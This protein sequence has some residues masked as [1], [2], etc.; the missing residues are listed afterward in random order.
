MQINTQLNM[1]HFHRVC[2]LNTQ[3]LLQK[4]HRDKPLHHPID[5]LEKRLTGLWDVLG[6]RGVDRDKML[7]KSMLSPA[8]CCL[9]NPDGTA[10]VERAFE[11]VRE[12]SMRL[13][14]KYKM[15]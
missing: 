15:P 2:Q 3:T 10:T 5:S 14:E 7:A 4:I 12:L 13:R 9:V 8:T 1:V 6:Q 11:C